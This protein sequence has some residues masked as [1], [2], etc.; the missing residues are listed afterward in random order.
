M[1]FW[2]S[3]R[4]LALELDAMSLVTTHGP[5]PDKARP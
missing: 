5:S 4:D 3:L 2:Q 1:T